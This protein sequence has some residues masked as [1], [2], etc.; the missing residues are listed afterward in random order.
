VEGEDDSQH[1][2]LVGT[3]SQPCETASASSVRPLVCSE[4]NPEP[5]V[6]GDGMGTV[7]GMQTNVYNRSAG[8]L[9]ECSRGQGFP[10]LPQGS[11]ASDSCRVIDCP[12]TTGPCSSLT[13]VVTLDVIWIKESGRIP[14]GWDIP[15]EMEGWECSIWV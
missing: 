3:L 8:L 14:I 1:R 13:G 6:F 7:G 11:L 2:G 5:L 15:L 4:G 9:V 12:A 10:E